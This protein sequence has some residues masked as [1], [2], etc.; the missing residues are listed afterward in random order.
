MPPPL[1]YDAVLCDLD[2]VLRH[3]PAHSLEHTHGLPEGALA[4]AAFASA[5]LLPAITGQITDEQW[6]AAV[7]ADLAADCGSIERA[8]AAVAAWSDLLPTVD[9]DVVALLTRVREVAAVAL[10]SNATT[11]LEWDLA[12]Q[13]LSDLAGSVVNTA[14]IGVAKPDPRVCRIAAEIVGSAPHRCLF[15]DDTEA[16]VMAARAVGMTAVHYRRLEDL[17]TALAPLLGPSA[18]VRTPPPDLPQPRA[19]G[20]P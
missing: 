19:G 20:S 9:R 6:R 2:G 3:W 16:N 18:D 15:V 7:T 1:R 8:S 14:R 5:R 17:R 11:R 4:A 10:V 12:R 13:G